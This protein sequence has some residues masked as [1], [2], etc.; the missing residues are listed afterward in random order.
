MH[1]NHNISKIPET[2][3]STRLT[4]TSEQSKHRSIEVKRVASQLASFRFDGAIYLQGFPTLGI[5]RNQVTSSSTELYAW[6][7][8][9]I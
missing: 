9:K 4:K 5:E 1:S 3:I 2:M 7:H 8:L 6:L